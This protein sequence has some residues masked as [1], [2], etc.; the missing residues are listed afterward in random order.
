M[1]LDQLLNRPKGGAKGGPSRRTHHDEVE[2]EYS[3]PA[4]PAPRDTYARPDGSPAA[5]GTRQHHGSASW[6]N[7]F[8]LAGLGACLVLLILLSIQLQSKAAMM[9][10]CVR[11]SGA[12][13]FELDS[14]KEQLFSTRTKL[15]EL[16]HEKGTLQAE[17]DTAA[18]K[19]AKM[20]EIK[21]T[22][23]GEL[24][25]LINKYMAL[26]RE[27]NTI[28]DKFELSKSEAKQLE[29]QSRQL[30]NLLTHLQSGIKSLETPTGKK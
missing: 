26:K 3:P 29:S 4:R 21:S 22:L 30:E 27:K 7:K 18:G 6:V 9:D 13:R 28:S 23:K 24:E 25:L 2:D 11:K 14:T 20:N 17:L 16:D 5:K 10:D 15:R 12:F 8:L 19:L 1:S